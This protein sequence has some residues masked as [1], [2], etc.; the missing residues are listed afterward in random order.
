MFFSLRMRPDALAAFLEHVELVKKM[1]SLTELTGDNLDKKRH[2]HEL[3]KLFE[4]I[5]ADGS[6]EITFGGDDFRAF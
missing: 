3:L 1:N 5:D 4:V 6:G 2:V